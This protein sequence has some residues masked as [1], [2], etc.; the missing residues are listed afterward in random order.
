M[1]EPDGR[2]TP[3]PLVDAALNAQA[4]RASVSTTSLKRRASSSFEG[5][6]GDTSRKRIKEDME[7]AQEDADDSDVALSTVSTTLAD[8]LARELECGCC[9]ELVYRPVLV[10]PCQ[11]FFCGSCCVLWI[12]NGGT[13][14]PACRGL[15]TVVTPFRALQSVIDTLIRAAPHKARTERERQQADEIYRL[16][17]SMRIPPPREPSPE[18]SVEIP[19]DYARPCPHCAAG[20][21]YGWRCPQ[22][23]PDPITDID[24]AWHLEDG[25]PPGHA[26]CGN[27]ENLLATRAPNTTTKCDLCQV[28]FCGIGVQNR[29]I[30]LPIH[31]QQPHGLSDIG[32]LI[33]SSDVYECFDS[34]H[35]EVEIM[36]DYLTAQGLTPRHIYREAGLSTHRGFK[37]LMELDLFT[38]IHGV[39]PGVDPDPEA[40]RISTCRHCATEIF[41]WG[42]RNWW[43]RERQKGFLEE[44][45]MSRKDCPD[46]RASHAKEY[47]HIFP[48]PASQPE[49]AIAQ[50]EHPVAEQTPEL[51]F[52]ETEPH[53]ADPTGQ[54]IAAPSQVRDVTERP[55]LPAEALWNLFNRGTPDRVPP[56]PEALS[57]QLA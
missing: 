19:T 39:A 41:L 30:A 15:S 42:L 52:P 45:V 34:N 12:R 7:A 11:H 18:T 22:P 35:V 3:T 38:D 49:Q 9:S 32:D 37:P 31:A 27:C 44:A 25:V 20:N 33:L 24:H 2:Q 56:Q 43:V 16:G 47:N 50:L 17:Q 23:I 57:S 55:E 51:R 54:A 46:G 14:C 5:C 26:H 36:L 29:C 28:Y 6:E 8:D 53:S 1:S 48:D 4:L 21:P 10:N 40:P 13:C